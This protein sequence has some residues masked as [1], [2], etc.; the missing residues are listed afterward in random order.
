MSSLH[1]GMWRTLLAALVVACLSVAV[2]D[3][4]PGESAYLRLAKAAHKCDL[5]AIKGLLDSELIHPNEVLDDKGHSPLTAA[6]AKGCAEGVKELLRY[7]AN[8]HHTVDALG[9]FFGF[10][11]LLLAARKGHVDVARTLLNS[12]DMDKDAVVPGRFAPTEH[13]M[14]AGHAAIHLAAIGGVPE[15][16]EVLIEAG[17]RLDVRVSDKHLTALDLA[18]LLENWEAA[19]VLQ[20]AGAPLSTYHLSWGMTVRTLRTRLYRIGK[21]LS[22]CPLS[23]HALLAG[24]SGARGPDLLPTVHSCHSS[25]KA[26]T[27]V[28]SYREA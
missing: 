22:W 4:E 10:N 27:R 11:A 16:V 21:R 2:C 18:L 8:V 5:V 14:Y 25:K 15:L 17:V 7:G 28:R 12:T 3:D 20:R 13:A 6:A 26:P 23:N 1:R 19:A 9:P 24:G